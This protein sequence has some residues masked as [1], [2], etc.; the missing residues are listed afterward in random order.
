L[1]NRRTSFPAESH[2]YNHY[3]RVWND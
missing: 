3:L 2:G 1:E